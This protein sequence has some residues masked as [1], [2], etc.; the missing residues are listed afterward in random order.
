MVLVILITTDYFENYSYSFGNILG[1]IRGFGFIISW[2][3]SLKSKTLSKLILQ[4]IF[5]LIYYDNIIKYTKNII[6]FIDRYVYRKYIL[7]KYLFVVKLFSL[8]GVIKCIEIREKALL[9][10]SYC[11]HMSIQTIES[12]RNHICYTF[13]TYTTKVNRAVFYINISTVSTPN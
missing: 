7:D 10:L 4:N 5:I 2:Y 3:F 1:N 12:K 6:N 8:N 13:I 9:K 11:H